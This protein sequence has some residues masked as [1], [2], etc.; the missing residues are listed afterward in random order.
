MK[1]L[2]VI[3]FICT[4]ALVI[5]Y[6]QLRN[7]AA[8][9]DPRGDQYAGA[10]TCIK[11]HSNL[12][13][14]YLHTAHFMASAP[15]GSHTIHGDFSSGKNVFTISSTQKLVMKKLDSGFYQS[16]YANGILKKRHRF[17]IVFGGVK[18]ETYLFW[19]GNELYQLPVSYFSKQHGWSTSPGYGFSFLDFSRSRAI[20]RQCM[21]CHSSY[22][23]DLPDATTGLAKA[24][25]FDKNSLIYSI[26]CERCHGP[27]AKHVDFQLHHP[28]VKTSRFITAYRS[29]NKG[30]Q[31][32]MCAV[33]HSGKPSIML[34]SGFTFMPGDT[35]AKFKLPEFTHPLD[36]GTPDVHGNQL[37]LLQSS[38]CFLNSTITCT[39][40]HDVHQNSR[41]NDALFTV[42]CLNCHNSVNHTYCKLTNTLS[43]AALRANCISCHMPALPTKVI[44]VQV[45]DQSPAIRFFVHTHHIGI[46]PQEVKKILAYVTH[47]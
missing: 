44:S 34:R 12:Y 42:K 9:A 25:Q 29:L 43:A 47:Q 1:K 38:K 15:A 5:A 7:N 21:E 3:V 18:G 28:E 10:K 39:T 27:A 8:K 4:A 24:E 23:S 20:G 17:D 6:F 40:C 37:Q 14:S 22:I 26:D 35:F 33:C 41:G 16:Y 11:C 30:Q 45:N 31:L 32:D 46:Y 13:T 36:T 2:V 19:K